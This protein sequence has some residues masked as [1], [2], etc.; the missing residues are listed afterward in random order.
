M[1]DRV[2][3]LSSEVQRLGTEVREVIAFIKLAEAA[4]GPSSP[5][6]EAL[7]QEAKEQA[8]A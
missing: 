1:S 5:G 3:L 7:R 4:F 8:Q 6:G 2:L